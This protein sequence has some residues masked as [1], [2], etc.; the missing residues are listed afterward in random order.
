MDSDLVIRTALTRTEYQAVENLMT[1][2]NMAED[3][4]LKLSIRLGPPNIPGEINQI[5]YYVDQ[6][7][8]GFCSLDGMAEVEICAAVHPEYRR[9]GIGHRLLETAL[10]A[11]RKHGT[12]RAVLI[13]ESGSR[14]GQEFV[15]SMNLT[16]STV[17]QRMELGELQPAPPFAGGFT[18]EEGT[19]DE[20]SAIADV[21]ARA[22]GDPVD[23]YCHRVERDM[24]RPDERWYLARVDGIPA[25]GVR[26]WN[27]SPRLFLYGVGVAPEMQ[28]RG[29][30]RQMLTHLCAQLRQAGG[31][32]IGLE[33]LAD[34]A[35]AKA[36]YRACGF[37]H[38]TTYEYYP[39]PL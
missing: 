31:E 25:G 33:V 10:E 34:N 22:F 32:R 6:K 2:C 16:P 9:R 5:L 7:L 17:E 39:L 36:L 30:G 24:R 23:E 3:L 8:V 15:A 14:S 29:V 12:Q 38:T 21:V 19:P 4:D 11:C 13:C 1:I 26:V 20:A 35:P 28:G 18:L 27:D 37:R